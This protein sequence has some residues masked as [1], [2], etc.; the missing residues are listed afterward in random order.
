MPLVETGPDGRR[1]WDAAYWSE[2][3]GREEVWRSG[4]TLAGAHAARW[5]SSPGA[6]WR[7]RTAAT[8]LADLKVGQRV[9]GIVKDVRSNGVFIDVG[10][11][12][13]GCLPANAA[14]ASQRTFREGDRVDG[15]I[16]GLLDVEGF[17]LGLRFVR[18]PEGRPLDSFRTGDTVHGTV[19]EITECGAFV[20]IG[21]DR[22][23]YISERDVAA[24]GLRLQSGD[25]LE[26]LVVGFVDV[27]KHRITLHLHDRRAWSSRHSR[28]DWQSDAWSRHK[29][30]DWWQR[31]RSQTPS[32]LRGQ[33][34]R[35]QSPQ[36]ACR[37]GR[38]PVYERREWS[39]SPSSAGTRCLKASPSR[40]SRSGSPAACEDMPASGPW[41]V[42]TLEWS[43]ASCGKP[44][45]SWRDGGAPFGASLQVL[46][47]K[48]VAH[49]ASRLTLE[50]VI[51]D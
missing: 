48:T 1:C 51:V 23:G 11:E 7:R 21:A 33:W 39:P 13:D 49:A 5:G 38:S 50:C 46:Q 18:Y 30:G 17:R 41:S 34:H 12:R 6:T 9:G 24:S 29:P 26:D 45:H 10:A 43:R 37:R 4:D 14:R 40:A 27:E 2:P 36:K 3:A 25:F 19:H 35:S 28:S 42:A 15:L 16:I 47:P 32:P 44:W 22:D 20:D 31:A 8:R